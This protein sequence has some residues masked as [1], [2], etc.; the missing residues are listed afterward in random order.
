MSR[1]RKLSADVWQQVL[2]PGLIQETILHHLSNA[3]SLKEVQAWVSLHALGKNARYLHPVFEEEEEGIVK[4]PVDHAKNGI[5]CA[6]HKLD[7]HVWTLLDT[8][9]TSEEVL[10]HFKYFTYVPWRVYNIV[11]TGISAQK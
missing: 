8:L 3:Y 6:L 4:T 5:K 10:S 9:T 7:T 1:K 11:R 2:G